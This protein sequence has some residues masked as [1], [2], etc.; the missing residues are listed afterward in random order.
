MSGDTR[1]YR[2]KEPGGGGPRCCRCCFHFQLSACQILLDHP[3]L[4]CF[5]CYSLWAC[6]VRKWRL[7]NW[8]PKYGTGIPLSAPRNPQLFHLIWFIFWSLAWLLCFLHNFFVESRQAGYAPRLTP[9]FGGCR[10]D[11]S[12]IMKIQI[13]I[14]AL[15]QS[16]RLAVRRVRASGPHPWSMCVQERCVLE[17]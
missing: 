11:C 8:R 1:C 10:Q 9:S 7:R 4:V 14:H 3:L 2:N 12:F 15:M 5:I 16:S 6:L 17:P 13:Q